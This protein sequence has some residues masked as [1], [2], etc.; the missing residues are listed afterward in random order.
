MILIQIFLVLFFYLTLSVVIRNNFLN[1]LTFVNFL[2]PS[3]IG[4][5]PVHLHKFPVTT[6]M[7]LYYF[8]RET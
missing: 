8:S 7:H 3:I 2:K 4:R 6:I 1:R 5:Y